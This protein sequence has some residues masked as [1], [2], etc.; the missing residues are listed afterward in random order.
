M[1]VAQYQND[2]FRQG[3]DVVYYSEMSEWGSRETLREHKNEVLP[4]GLHFRKKLYYP[5]H[6]QKE[7]YVC[8]K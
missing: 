1:I 2:L 5:V 8:L 7:N 6:M 4:L 3:D